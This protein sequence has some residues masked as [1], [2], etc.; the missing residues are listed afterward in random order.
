MSTT[1]N[2][3]TLRDAGF[4]VDRVPQEQQAALA[5]LSPEE[6]QTLVRIQQRMAPEGDVQGYRASDDTGYLVF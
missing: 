2:I 3:Q 4:P 6:V 5:E 1:D